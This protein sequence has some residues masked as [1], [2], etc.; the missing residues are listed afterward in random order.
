MKSTATSPDDYLVSLPEDRQAA[1]AKI[2]AVIL[3]NLPKGYQESMNWGM[4]CYEVPPE[5]YPNTYNNQPLMYAALASQKNHMA[6]Y[7]TGIQTSK[8]L[9]DSFEKDYKATGKKLDMGKSCI[10]FKRLEELPLDVIGKH[11]SKVSPAALIAADQKVH[12]SK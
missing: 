5:T 1:L 9:T 7:L 10:R 12:G 8:E 3:K 4:I 2:R 6:L 11:I